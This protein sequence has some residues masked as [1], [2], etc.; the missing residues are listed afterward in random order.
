[1]FK[2]LYL[3]IGLIAFGAVASGVYKVSDYYANVIETNLIREAKLYD[4]HGHSWQIAELN[5]EIGIIYFGYTSCPDICPNAL[6]NLSITLANMGEDSKIFQPIFVSV[7]PDRDTSEV[8]EEYTKHFGENILGLTGTDAQL[9]TFSWIFGA[10]YSLRKS[11]SKNQDYIV[12]HSANYFLVTSSGRFLKLPVKDN[13]KDL[14]MLLMRSK[15][16]ILETR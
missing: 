14:G 10:S 3:L 1:M 11:E 9:R 12:D 16:S 13:P 15:S 6:N 2:I 8:I 7:D 5:E 4:A